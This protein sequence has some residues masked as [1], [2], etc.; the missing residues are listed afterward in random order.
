MEPAYDPLTAVQHGV[1]PHENYCFGFGSTNT[2]GYYITTMKLSTG[3][4]ELK[5]LEKDETLL[6]IAAYDKAESNDAYLGQVNMIGVSSFSGPYSAIWGYD[7]AKVDDSVLRGKVLFT[8]KQEMEPYNTINAYSMDPLL[9]AT[10]DLFGEVDN[11]KFPVVPGGHLP[12]A[13]KSKDSVSPCTKMPA[14]G[15]VWAYLSIAIADKRDKNAS[16]F[17]EDVGFIADENPIRQTE[18]QVDAFL[19]D[20]AKRV[21]YSQILC[22]KNQAISFKEIFI[23]WRKLRVDDG[24]Y[25]TALTCAPYITLAQKV[26]P[27]GSASES[28]ADQLVKMSLEQWKSDVR[29]KQV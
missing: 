8:I 29:D 9:D 21:A 15:W 1:S 14:A 24:E 25:G 27:D 28:S 10:Q 13:V 4:V 16:L 23:S 18:E 22:G 6:T 11:L 17:V 5:P 12:T 19:T 2:N 7:M 26:Y 20:K 3:K